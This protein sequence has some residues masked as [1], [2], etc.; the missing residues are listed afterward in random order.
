MRPRKSWWTKKTKLES[1]CWPWSAS[2]QIVYKC[3]PTAKL[4]TDI[5]KLFTDSRH[6]HA[7]CRDVLSDLK[8]G[9][10]WVNDSIDCNLILCI[11]IFYVTVLRYDIM[12]GTTTQTSPP[13]FVRTALVNS[14]P[15]TLC[16][17]T[18]TTTTGKAISNVVMMAAS[19]TRLP[20]FGLWSGTTNWLLTAPLFT[21]AI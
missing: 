19:L 5:S 8:I 12:F 10:F 3:C 11:T 13:G 9:E 4:S 21:R 20:R 15:T 7:W 18:C 16:T 6:S 1:K 2:S 17:F 14:Q